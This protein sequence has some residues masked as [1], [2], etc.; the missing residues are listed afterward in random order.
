ML[1]AHAAA[2]AIVPPPRNVQ[3]EVNISSGQALVTWD[4]PIDYSSEVT[5]Y[6]V[7]RVEGMARERLETVPAPANSYLAPW[8]N[9]T[10]AYYV[11]AVEG[12][13]ESV[14][15][16]TAGYPYCWI[17]TPTIPPSPVVRCFWPPPIGPLNTLINLVPHG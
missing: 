3:A 11:T 17:V 13:V 4:E 8:D 6:V 12:T 1:P 9:E 2:D 16:G 14:P 7:Y 15:M 10:V 5:A